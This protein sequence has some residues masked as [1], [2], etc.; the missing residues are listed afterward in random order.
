MLEIFGKC[1]IHPPALPLHS[2]SNPL[3]RSL[4][5]AHP[6]SPTF[7]PSLS[8]RRS[9]TLSPY[10]LFP[11]SPLSPFPPPPLYLPLSLPH[12]SPPLSLSP[13]AFPQLPPTCIYS[14]TDVSLLR[15]LPHNTTCRLLHDSHE[16]RVRSIQKSHITG[17]KFNGKQCP[18]N[19][20]TVN[21]ES[22]KDKHSFQ[23]HAST[24]SMSIDHISD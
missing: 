5:H 24:M 22:P 10:P 16:H 21:S 13:P 9:P 23:V 1:D 15:M 12:F 19:V 11:L 14:N 3:S 6:L 2:L 18:V 4:A 7:S 8:L 20:R 17:H